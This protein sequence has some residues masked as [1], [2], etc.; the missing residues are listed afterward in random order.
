MR[1]KNRLAFINFMWFIVWAIYEIFRNFVENVQLKEFENW[2]TCAK[3][4]FVRGMSFNF[5]QLK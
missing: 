2:Q 5:T 4:V 3:I 1:K